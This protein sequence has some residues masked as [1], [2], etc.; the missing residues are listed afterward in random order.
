MSSLP[1]LAPG[2]TVE[3]V[4]D[5]LLVVVPGATE[6][7][8]LS[9]TAALVVRDIVNGNLG[10][11]SDIPTELFDLGIIHDSRR[12]SRR[13]ALKLG[14]MGAG[15]GIAVMAM[16][17]VAA[18]SSATAL[19]GTLYA[20]TWN[21]TG[22]YPQVSAKIGATDPDW[23]GAIFGVTDA[24]YSIDGLNND[25]PVLD[26]GSVAQGTVSTGGASYT[27]YLYVYEGA[28]FWFFLGPEDNVPGSGDDFVLTFSFGGAPY[29]VVQTSP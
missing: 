19:S 27:A 6:A 5:D 12:F 23:V 7:L 29:R 24:P 8:K 14:A 17:T 10:D 4:G 16:P 3:A 18:A 1:S 25:D 13:T 20:E 2:V 11:R 21:D 28:P 26:G 9:G 15:A 22:G